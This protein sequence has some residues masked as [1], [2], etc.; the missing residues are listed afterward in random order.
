MKKFMFAKY[1]RVARNPQASDDLPVLLVLRL[2]GLQGIGDRGEP[3]N[4]A[5][6]RIYSF[7][8]QPLADR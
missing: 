3:V 5:E 4:S 2:K 7:V 1:F 8:T 6:A